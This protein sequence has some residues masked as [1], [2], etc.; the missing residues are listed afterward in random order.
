VYR[1]MKKSRIFKEHLSMRLWPLSIRFLKKAKRNFFEKQPAKK[2]QNKKLQFWILF[3][4]TL[5]IIVF[6]LKIFFHKLLRLFYLMIKKIC[7]LFDA[8][9]VTQDEAEERSLE[10]KLFS[11]LIDFINFFIKKN[12]WEK[13]NYDEK[14]ESQFNLTNDSWTSWIGMDQNGDDLYLCVNGTSWKCKVSAWRNK[15]IQSHKCD[16]ILKKKYKYYDQC[17]RV[18]ASWETSR[19][20]KELLFSEAPIEVMYLSWSR[21]GWEAGC[22]NFEDGGNRG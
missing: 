9:K 5:G 2:L 4:C 19:A 11:G 18:L 20:P 16:L 14:C 15:M 8:K 21:A 1:G 6:L 10:L 22:L 3:A 13:K 17:K 12:M 7:G